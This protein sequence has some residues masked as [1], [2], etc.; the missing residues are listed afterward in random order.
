M[1]ERQRTL[2]FL[3]ALCL[4][5]CVMLGV[6]DY[7]GSPAIDWAYSAWVGT[8]FGFGI[9]TAAILCFTALC[10]SCRAM[11]GRDDN[12]CGKCGKKLRR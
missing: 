8:V 2:A 4:G 9:A 10:P 1:N 7:L 3:W 11:I 6:F 12:Y 5:I